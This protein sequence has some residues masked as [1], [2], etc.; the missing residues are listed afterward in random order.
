VRQNEAAKDETETFL[1]T[2]ISPLARHYDYFIID[3]FGVIHDGIRPFPGTINCLKQLNDMG[4]EIC[5]LSNSPKRAEG[6]AAQMKAMGISGKLFHHVVTSGEA[7]YSALENRS[8]EFHQSCGRDCWFIGPR[9]MAAMLDGL[10]LNLVDGPEKASF[11]LNAIPG[12]EPSM[13]EIL[14][15]QMETAKAHDLPMICANPDLVVNIGEKQYECAGTFARHYEEI[16]GRVLYHGKPHK[17]VYERCHELF[18]RPDKSR[19]IALGDS[20]HTDIAGANRFGIDSALNLVGIHSEEM[21][22]DH[23]PTQA[24]EAKILKVLADQPHQPTHILTGFNW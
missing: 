13:V 22:M 18:G 2:G 14:M 6:A 21:H 16:G 1:L 19:I 5:L 15:R 3:I 7:T 9:A 17:P 10:G 20:L 12:T 23:D 11:I 24:D 8:D 4:K